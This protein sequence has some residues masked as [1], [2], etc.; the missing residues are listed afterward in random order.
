MEIT[1]IFSPFVVPSYVPLGI[2]QL[3]S[4]IQSESPSIK[5]HNLDLNNRFFRDLKNSE[6]VSLCRDLCRICPQKNK[7]PKVRKSIRKGSILYRIGVDCLTD[8]ESNEFY[9]I[10]K[11]N[12]FIEKVDSFFSLWE[13]C[14]SII[15]KDIIQ[16]EKR[17]PRPLELIFRNDINRIRPEE[18]DLIGFSVFAHT[19]LA[20]SLLLAK[21]LKQKIKRPI[22]FGGAFMNYID[23]KAFLK[24]FDFIDFIINKE[25]E[26]GLTEL[27]KN[28]KNKDF[29]KVPGLFYRRDSE[30]IKNNDKF[31]ENLDCLPAPEFNDFDLNRY[32]LPVPV[33]PVIFS[34]GCFWKRCT[35]CVY[36]KTYPQ[37]YKTKSIRKFIEEIKYYISLGC[38]HFFIDDD[39]IS[40]VSLEEISVA[41]I[42]NKIKI[43]FGVIVRPERFFSYKVLKSIY[44]AGGRVLYW[45]VESSCQNI[46]DLMNKG[47]RIK[48]IK[49]ILENSHKIGFHNHV[50]MIRGFPGQ[51]EN[52]IKKDIKFLF[53][54]REVIDSYFIHIFGLEKG[55]YIH[56]NPEKFKINNFKDSVIYKL[57][58]K[59]TAIC[60]NTLY[61]RSNTELNWDSI[62]QMEN[63]TFGPRKRI[64]PDKFTS[65]EHGHTLLHTSLKRNLRAGQ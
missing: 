11:Y 41:L 60:Y 65:F 61:F 23:A 5:V 43:C 10:H 39:A 63:K 30:V 54:N 59:K 33:I 3:K 38:K 57:K 22:V 20:Y 56:N 14:I 42:K 25:G 9:N 32:L 46:L 35:F 19:Q 52:D 51:T 36:Y 50:F 49:A 16:N 27:A 28:L 64:F 48:D 1:L 40:A 8:K 2:A 18:T 21:M 45:G 13:N 24:M 44:D 34:R 37:A 15:A 26:T 29:E 7:H 47:T 12:Y 4:Y 58:K 6:F 62:N 31:I 53:D 17:I 55:S